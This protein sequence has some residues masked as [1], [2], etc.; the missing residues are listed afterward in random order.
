MTEPN[1]SR[2]SP[3][4]ALAGACA[5]LLMSAWPRAASAQ[6]QGPT[7][8]IVEPVRFEEIQERR[9][10][11]GELRPVQRA[12]I[13][14]EEPGR[15]IALEVRE[16][17]RVKRGDLIAKLEATRLELELKRVQAQRLVAQAEVEES[18]ASEQQAQVDLDSLRSLQERSA[19][20]PKELSDA[21]SALAVAKA[22]RAASEAQLGVLSAE[23]A[24]FRDRLEDMEIRAPFDGTI[25]TKNT[26]LGQWVSEGDPV[27]ELLSDESIE[28]WLAVPQQYISA[29]QEPGVQIPI[30]IEATRQEYTAENLRVIPLVDSSARNFALVANLSADGAP[31]LAGMSLAAHVPTGTKGK[32]LTIHPDAI[33]RSEIGAYC[34]V[35][36]GGGDG[37]P[38]QAMPATLE[39]LFTQGGRVAVR[40]PALKEG[41]LVVIEGNERLFPMTPV[42]PT[43][44]P[45]V[46]AGGGDGE[47]DRATSEDNGSQT[48]EKRKADDR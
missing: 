38:A 8:V 21:D 32:H 12:R 39:V 15:V 35:A 48:P 6:G 27:A 11:T 2:C 9:R 19:T 25:L 20:R 5:V 17:Q 42:A 10:V 23:E 29:V 36:R 22:R 1:L 30:L 26:E 24:L 37:A 43:R 34:W 31:L 7:P 14:A 46:T 45:A 3:R 18:K 47:S 40:S 13:A 28:A 33:L 41:D 44:E 16:G 4:L